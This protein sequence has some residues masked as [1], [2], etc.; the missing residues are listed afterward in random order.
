MLYISLALAM[1]TYVSNANKALTFNLIEFR[2]RER[3]TERE[4]DGSTI[5]YGGRR[6]TFLW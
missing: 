6:V 3:E 4:R 1:L 5:L 2:E